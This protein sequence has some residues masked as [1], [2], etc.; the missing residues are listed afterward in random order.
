MERTIEPKARRGRYIAD[1]GV[2]WTEFIR[3]K[4]K[5]IKSKRKRNKEKEKKRDV[6]RLDEREQKIMR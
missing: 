2:F 6:L 3:G 5:E 4:K 1:C